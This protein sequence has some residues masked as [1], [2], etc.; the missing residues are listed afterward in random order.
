ML[1]NEEAMMGAQVSIKGICKLS[2]RCRQT[3][4]AELG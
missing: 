2:A 1:A 4:V 3:W